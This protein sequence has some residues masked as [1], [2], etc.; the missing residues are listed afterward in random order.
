MILRQCDPLLD[1]VDRQLRAGGLAP[2]NYHF[3]K[4]CDRAQ[5]EISPDKR[6]Y[7]VGDALQCEKPVQNIVHVGSEWGIFWNTTNKPASQ[8]NDRSIKPD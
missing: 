2:V 3:G 5:P 4:H 1:F 8:M 6:C 7:P